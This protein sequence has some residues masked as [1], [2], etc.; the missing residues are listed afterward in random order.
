MNVSRS[1]EETKREKTMKEKVSKMKKKRNHYESEN[2]R[3][4]KR[5]SRKRKRVRRD[6]KKGTLLSRHN[7]V[8]G[9]LHPLNK[10]GGKRSIRDDGIDFLGTAMISTACMQQL[11]KRKQ[12]LSKDF[13]IDAC[14]RAGNVRACVCVCVFVRG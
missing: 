1:K 11:C 2:E 12:G 7:N 14:T 6:R 8:D 13:F 10:N 3:M 9:G 5:Y 4:T